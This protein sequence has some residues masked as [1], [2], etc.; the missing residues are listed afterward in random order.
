MELLL[1]VINLVEIV[2]FFSLFFLFAPLVGLS[3]PAAPSASDT[4]TEAAI[5][6]CSENSSDVVSIKSENGEGE[7]VEIKNDET[8]CDAIKNDETKINDAKNSEIKTTT[9]KNYVVKNPEKIKSLEEADEILLIREWK[10]RKSGVQFC[11][12]TSQ[13]KKIRFSF[14][15]NLEKNIWKFE[16]PE[17]TW[18]IE[19][20]HAHRVKKDGS[21][22]SYPCS[23]WLGFLKYPIDKWSK[24]IKFSEENCD[25][26]SCF[27]LGRYKEFLLLIRFFVNPFSLISIEI[28]SDAAA[29]YE[30]I[31]FERS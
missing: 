13:N 7:N 26:N 1:V 14:A 4:P 27:S 30:K 29:V 12:T 18:I 31:D 20:S 25:G 21:K 11:S 22:R 6:Q 19:N 28:A 3:D 10:T 16:Y 5:T 8:E 24:I 9:I 23:S 2:K 15:W 17:I